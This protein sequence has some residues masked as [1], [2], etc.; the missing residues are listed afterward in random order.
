MVVGNERGGE[1]QVLSGCLSNPDFIDKTHVLDAASQITHRHAVHYML[2]PIRFV[3]DR[4]QVPPRPQ[5]LRGACRVAAWLLRSSGFGARRESAS[6]VGQSELCNE[7]TMCRYCTRGDACHWWG[8]LVARENRWALDGP[9][10][11]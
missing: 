3:F 4:T 8:R 9:F 10:R 5:W 7:A 1:A 11:G 6:R 2:Q